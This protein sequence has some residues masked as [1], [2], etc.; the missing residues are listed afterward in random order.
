MTT[1]EQPISRLRVPEEQELPDSLQRFFRATREAE[2]HLPNWLAA[3]SLG[4]EQ[5]ARLK[6][7]VLP[8]LS[9]GSGHL[10]PRE[11]EIIA[12]VVSVRNGCSYCHTLHVHSLAEVLGDRWLAERTGIDH[13]EVAELSEREH[14]LADLATTVTTAPREVR[15]R[16][17]EQLRELGL[18][19]AAVFE[20]VQVAAV[21]NATNRITLAL[22]V[23]PDREI[24]PS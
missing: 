12:T 13:R 23:L 5:F 19:D 16:E 17:V 24:F 18:D 10:T 22:G 11:R 21:I 7:Y 15:E 8:L 2:G 20:A 3:F 6:D 9:G 1:T 14:A 4:G